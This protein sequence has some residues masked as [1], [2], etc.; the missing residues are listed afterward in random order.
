[1]EHPLD[2]RQ[3]EGVEMELE[4]AVAVQEASAPVQ[5][6]EWIIEEF[7][8]QGPEPPRGDQWEAADWVEIPHLHYIPISLARFKQTLLQ[9]PEVLAKKDLFYEFF[10]LMNLHVHIQHYTVLLELKEDYEFFS[11]STGAYARRGVSKEELLWRERR[12]LGNFLKTMVKGNFSPFREEDYQQAIEHDYL[13]D[14]PVEL[15]WKAYDEE[16]FHNFLTMTPEQEQELLQHVELEG[17]LHDF[18]QPPAA[19]HGRIWTF[20]RGLGREQTRGLFLPAKVDLMLSDVVHWLIL[21]F[22]WLVEKAR[23]ESSERPHH[24]LHVLK[25][26]LFGEGAEEEEK[27]AYPKN[28]KTHHFQRRWMRR[29]NLQNQPN[30]FKDLLTQR[31]LQEPTYHRIISLFRMRTEETRKWFHKLPLLGEVLARWLP[32]LEPQE[33]DWTIYIKLFH[34]IPMADSEMI[35]PARKLRMKSLD[36]TV[37]VMTGLAGIFAMYRGL[38]KSGSTLLLVL[39]SVMGLYVV[40]LILGYRRVRARYLARVTETLYNKNL[41]NDMGV[42]EYLVSSMEEQDLKESILLYFLLWRTQSSMTLEQLDEQVE[43]FVSEKF[44]GIEVDFEVGDALHKV[45]DS[46][47]DTPADSI[48]LVRAYQTAEGQYI[49]QARPLE[50]AL[51]ILQ[52]RWDQL[53]SVRI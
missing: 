31:T 43:F 28:H 39:L 23:G 21:P 50:E 49:Y 14:L 25:K 44:Q 6:G 32:P 46:G 27:E 7:V 19:F 45:L 24:S 38:Q 3:T 8:F 48:P 33:K 42:L 51:V 5:V 22:Q 34:E 20:Y 2:K 10:R 29:L 53:H 12:F 11:A 35:Y 37:L 18:V 30:S 1:M 16:L 52:Q 41:N 17:S 15:H 13:F 9:T 26:A 47:L 36:I 4:Q 40:K